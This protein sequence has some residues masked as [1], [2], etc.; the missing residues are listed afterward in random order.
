MVMFLG[1]LASVLIFRQSLTESLI[2]RGMQRFNEHYQAKFTVG[3]FA[4]DGL[5]GLSFR[6]ITLKP[7]QGDSLMR[8]GYFHA[9]I[10]IR[11]LLRFKLALRNLEMK[12]VWFHFVRRDSLTNYMFLFD[13]GIKTADKLV[14]PDQPVDYA[15]RVDRMLNAM[16]DKIP[17]SITI[18]NLRLDANMNSNKF[19]FYMEQL[20]ISGHEFET[21]IVETDHGKVTPWV[22]RGDLDAGNR[23]ARFKLFA[24]NHQAI[25]FPYIDQRWNTYIA[26]DTMH[27]SLSSAGITDNVLTLNGLAS[28][29]KLVINQPRLSSGDVFFDRVLA[30]YHINIAPNYFELDS[31]SRFIFNKIGL[32]PYLC[33][34]AEPSKQITF[35][36]NKPHFNANNFFE[37]LP[38]GLFYN[39]EGIKASG[40][41]SFH[42]KFLV[43]LARPDDLVFSCDLERQHFRIM[44]YGNTNFSKI[45]APFIYTAYEGGVAVRTFEI[46]PS[47][48]NFRKLDAVPAYL[49][50]AIMTSEDGQ[51]YDHR[52][53]QLDAFRQA[54]ITNIKERRFARGGSTIS[55]QLIKNVFLNRNK[56][57]T[58]KLEE[59]LIV[60]LIENND[61][62]S[63]NRMYEVYL[64]II[65]MGP[66]IYGVNEGA[67]FYFGKDVSQ[68]S[69]AEAIYM[70]SI[71]PHPKW[72]RYSFERDGYL[73]EFLASYYKL[74]SEKMFHKG[75]ITQKDFDAL[76]PQVEL[77]GSAKWVVLPA[78][79]IPP[80]SVKLDYS[81]EMQAPSAVQ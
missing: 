14:Q 59:A 52:G 53:F 10:N 47:N 74:V 45:N 33:F 62:S 79:S 34:R 60:W 46:G 67:Q 69:L 11:K 57:I 66:M 3:S 81:T 37:S 78:D 71:V 18:N 80:I 28:A 1:L 40:D 77:K 9:N 68:L 30:D 56:T 16:F 6:N 27:F 64:N 24:R 42:L 23:S 54:I 72:F 49:R 26:S 13:N 21:L 12:D 22:L 43:D 4:F 75:L 15:D 8:I 17:S 50:N 44:S 7:V 39:L 5:S 61:L 76:L 65:E 35:I 48:P 41:L 58:R 32:N 25:V 73:R 51:F 20:A 19:G 36:L 63:K 2:I 38:K 29:S 70:A 55:M 31:T